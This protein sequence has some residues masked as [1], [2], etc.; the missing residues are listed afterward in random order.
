[1]RMQEAGKSQTR[2]RMYK[3]HI[4]KEGEPKIHHIDYVWA[5]SARQAEQIVKDKKRKI[6]EKIRK[7]KAGALD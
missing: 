2:K 7:V 5:A 6:G 3:V 1:M 4:V